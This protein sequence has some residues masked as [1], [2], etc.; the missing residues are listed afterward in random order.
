MSTSALALIGYAAWTLLLVITIVT[1]RSWMSLV[2]KRE[3]YPPH[4]D[5]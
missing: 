3:S 5:Q 2:G 1:A 4:L